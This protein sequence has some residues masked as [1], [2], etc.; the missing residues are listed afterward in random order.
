MPL[1]GS[2]TDGFGAFSPLRNILGGITLVAWIDALR[3]IGKEEIFPDFQVAFLQNRQYQFP[4][5]AKSFLLNAGIWATGFAHPKTN[6]ETDKKF[7]LERSGIL[8]KKIL[9]L[10]PGSI[11]SPAC[12]VDIAPPV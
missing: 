9:L 4:G 5:R 6:R 8:A 11:F 10:C 2:R 3:G 1:G 7:V 12:Q